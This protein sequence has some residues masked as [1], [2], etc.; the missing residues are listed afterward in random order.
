MTQDDSPGSLIE[1]M[2][3]A[4]LSFD[5]KLCLNYINAA[6]EILL[7][8]SARLVLG[9]PLRVLFHT[10]PAFIA[11]VSNALES[12][13]AYSERETILMLPNMHSTTVNYTVTPIDEPGQRKSLLLE[14]V[15][16]DRQLRIAREESLLAQNQTVRA[17]MRG[18]AHEIKNP[19]GGLRGAAQLL[20][21]ELP[22]ESLQEYTQVII[23]EADR[24][25]NLL[26]SMLGPK[27][28][29]KKRKINIHSVLEHV[30]TLV[31]AEANA[32]ITIERDYDPS[33][34]EL[35]GD[36]EQLIQAILNIVRNAVQSLGESGRIILHTRT[37]RQVTI[38]HQRHRLAL[39]IDIIDNGPGIPDKILEDI[40]YPMVTGRAEGTGLGLPIAQSL[41]NLHNGLIECTSQ[42]QETVF[43][44]FL[45]LESKHE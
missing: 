28:P 31:Q 33:I 7:E 8:T 44:I 41:I 16:V 29:P 3:T 35:Y 34:P 40:F 2:K 4:L 25:Q 5:D 12:G 19:L 24:L 15:Q 11:A 27:T 6:G 43:T 26:D 38:G 18:M 20:E 45:P 21:R 22:D 42:P 13:L 32:G 23:D 30:R 1:H 37:Q 9:Q 17:L 10:A 36:P 39:R 14:M